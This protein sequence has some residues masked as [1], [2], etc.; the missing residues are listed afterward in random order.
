[1]RRRVWGVVC[2]L[3]LL[4]ALQL[5]RPSAIFDAHWAREIPFTIPPPPDTGLPS[6][7]ETPRT[8]APQYFAYTASLCLIVSRINYQLYLSP[9]QGGT[10]DEEGEGVKR[11]ESLRSELERWRERL[12]NDLRVQVASGSG[13]LMSASGAAVVVSGKKGSMPVLDV[14]LLYYVALI[15]LYRPL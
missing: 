1:M 4:I 6:S 9:P 13:M 8:A 12:P 14:N 3:D 2:I 15:L 7:L 10:S 11:L 5:G